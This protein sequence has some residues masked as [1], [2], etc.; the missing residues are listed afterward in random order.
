MCA[1]VGEMYTQQC[2]L[3]CANR[4]YVASASARRG[5]RHR[6]LLF[7]RAVDFA[8]APTSDQSQHDSRRNARTHARTHANRYKPASQQL[9]T[10]VLQSRVADQQ[11][12]RADK[13]SKL[14]PSEQSSLITDW[15][16]SENLHPTLWRLVRLVDKR[17]S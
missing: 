12:Q 10:S 7:R 13:R 14:A 1:A 6:R 3:I 4:N 2:A 17:W 8:D 16:K 11:P 5:R 15:H 9:A